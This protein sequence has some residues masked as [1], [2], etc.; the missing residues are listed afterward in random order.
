MNLKYFT[1]K[2]E[3]EKA[4]AMAFDAGTLLAIE[5]NI[6]LGFAVQNLGGQLKY[7]SQKED[8]PLNFKLSTKYKPMR[9]DNPPNILVDINIPRGNKVNFNVGIE[10]W[11]N[12]AVAVRGGYKDKVDEGKIIAGLGFRSSVFQLD[13]AYMWANELEAAHRISAIFRFGGDKEKNIYTS[14]KRA[15]EQRFAPRDTYYDPELQ[16][17]ERTKRTFQFDKDLNEE[18]MFFTPLG[19]IK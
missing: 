3:E 11:L 14:K 9:F 17:K 7:I 4:N 13:Y 19:T 5:E 1:S 8:L 18:I 15:F 12:E 10:M 2:I 16:T 6:I